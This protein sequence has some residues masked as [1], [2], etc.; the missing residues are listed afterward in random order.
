MVWPSRWRPWARRHRL[1]A[2]AIRWP[3]RSCVWRVRHLPGRAAPQARPAQLQPGRRLRGP[4]SAYLAFERCSRL[5]PAVGA[6]AGG[7]RRR[8]RA[9]DLCRTM[10]A[11]VSPPRPRPQLQVLASEYRPT[12]RSRRG[13]PR[14]SANRSRPLT[15]AA[16]GLKF[17]DP[18]GAT[19][20]TRPSLH[21]LRRPHLPSASL[22]PLR[23]AGQHRAHQ[24]ASR[25][26]VRAGEYGRHFPERG[27]EEPRSNLETRRRGQG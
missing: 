3:R 17:Y 2:W 14:L 4:T 11:Q 15:A 13:S 22:R 21:R 19:S 24:R 25:Y 5:R 8:P 12:P 10:G 20:S 1:R 26:R 7:W 9:V 16:R 6:G 18:V 27:R 23:C